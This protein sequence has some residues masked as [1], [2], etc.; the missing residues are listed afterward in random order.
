MPPK[1]GKGK[2]NDDWP[3]DDD[4]VDPIKAAASKGGK[5][6]AEQDIAPAP[7]K[8]KS[9]KLQSLKAE[10]EKGDDEEPQLPKMT[11]P[12]QPSKA[13]GKKKGKNKKDYD[14]WY[15][16]KEPTSILDLKSM[17][18]D[19]YEELIPKSKNKTKQKK[20]TQL[21]DSE[22]EVPSDVDPKGKTSK[23]EEVYEKIEEENLKFKGKGKSKKKKGY[24]DEDQLSDELENQRGNDEKQLLEEKKNKDKKK[25]GKASKLQSDKEDGDNDAIND[26]EEQMQKL[27]VKDD[28]N[29]LPSDE[30]SDQEKEEVK[31]LEELQVKLSHKDKKKLKKQQEYEKQM[32]IV[33]RKGGTGHSELGENFTISQAQH[34]EKKAA[35]LENAVDIK[36]EN[37][38]ISAKGKSLFTNASLLIAQGRRYGLVGP[39]G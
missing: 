17:K 37:F 30:G 29:D 20:K 38:S 4:V 2:K 39:N 6:G 26:V 18:S 10:L 31:K 24:S 15:S 28:D 8:L 12:P 13:T 27:E 5:K 9:K 21:D 19:D 25:K 11:D 34:S 36:V 23:A 35:L 14:E 32:E 1:K 16:D 3:S 7:T 22:D 33:N